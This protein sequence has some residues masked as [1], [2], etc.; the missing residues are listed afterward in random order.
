MIPSDGTPF[1][2]DV[3]HVLYL[4]YQNWSKRLQTLQ[5]PAG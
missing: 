2:V 4:L 1:S 3:C 5:P